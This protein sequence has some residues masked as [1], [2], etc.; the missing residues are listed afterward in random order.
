MRSFLAAL[1]ATGAAAL[2]GLALGGAHGADATGDRGA[3]GADAAG[4][5]AAPGTTSSAR[6][7]G[8]AP[9]SAAVTPLPMTE[10]APG[11]FVQFGAIEDWLPSNGGNVANIGFV[12]GRRCVAVVDTGGTPMVG[13]RLRAAIERQTPLPV[14][15][16]INTH[17]H[18]DHVLGDSAFA[19]PGV[20][21]IGSRRFPAAMSAREP[22]YLNAL[23]RDFGIELAHEAV[24]YPSRTVDGTL[25]LDLGERVLQLESW[26]TAHTDNDLTV[27]DRATRTLFLSDLLFVR[28]LPVLDGRLR[29]WLAVMQTL[30]SR[31]VALAVPGHGPASRDW[32]GVM[33][34]QREYLEALQRDTRAA[35]KE[36]RTLAETVERVAP[37][38]AANWLLIER[39]H[40]RNVTAAYAE[41]EWD[42]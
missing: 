20:E 24:A 32:P 33:A 3:H 8:A 7:I 26:P 5:S 21:F 10:L 25:E 16:V 11:V 27:Y 9:D 22:Y 23:K 36:G 31:D 30:Q 40:R 41:L 42:E 28:H 35:L 2:I 37:A 38:S 6:T 13:R 39:F 34:A 12:V 18:P 4:D 15:Y 17:A 19:G 29:G 14:C 1:A